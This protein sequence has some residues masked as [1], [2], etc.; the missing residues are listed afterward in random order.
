MIGNRP[1]MRFAEGD[2][3][4]DEIVAFARKSYES[5]GADGEINLGR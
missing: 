2:S 4:R 5:A 3:D 1:E